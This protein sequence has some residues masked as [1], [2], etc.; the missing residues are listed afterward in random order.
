MVN[1]GISPEQSTGL[2]GAVSIPHR[3][4][5]L[6]EPVELTIS[7][8]KA[9]EFDWMETLST[10]GKPSKIL[11]KSPFITP[12]EFK[13]TLSVLEGK[14]ISRTLPFPDRREEYDEVAFSRNSAKVIF[15]IVAL[16]F[17]DCLSCFTQSGNL[18]CFGASVVVVVV[19]VVVVVVLVAV[20]VG[21]MV[22]VDTPV[23]G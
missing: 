4:S 2:I 21:A 8:C 13:R 22:V 10:P 23:V 14:P 7:G 20:V 11:F 17:N 18:Y 9:M 12:V 5:S 6:R 1:E 16:Q 15:G 3:S 19:L